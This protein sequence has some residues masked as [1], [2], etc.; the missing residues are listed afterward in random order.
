MPVFDANINDINLDF[1]KDKIYLNS[2][3]RIL[4]SDL[5]ASAVIR[6][7][8]TAPLIFDNINL[9]LE[10]ININK[11]AE[12]LRDY[13]VNSA[14][15]YT[16]TSS[17][18]PDFSGIIIKKAEITADKIKIKEL[19]ANNFIAHLTLND[20]MILE[21][22]D[23]KFNV[24]GGIS[25][26]KVKYNLLNHLVNISANVKNANAQTIAETLTDLKGQVYG[27]VA[28]EINVYCN[29]KSHDACVQTLGG[30]GNFEISD[31]KMPK[32]GSLEYL[33]KAGNLVKG[34]ITGLSIKGIIDLITPYKT[35]QFDSIKGNFKLKD[36]IANDLKIY[37][38]GKALNIF[39]NGSYNLNNQI[40]DMSIFGALTNN[41]SSVIGKIGAASLNTLFNTM[42]WINLSDI[43]KEQTDD[44]K[45]IPNTENA[46]RMF[47]AIIYGDINGNDYVRSF[48]WLK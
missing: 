31:G 12:I 37:S 43:P 35:G 23:F 28:G 2:K 13:D 27:N 1:R 20:K 29:G 21:V 19:L 22:P 9:N 32:L 42:P 7:K 47:N 8:L 18:L 4:T 48:K 5:K 41:F 25:S 15:T 10:T 6:N 14:R 3:G 30:N 24:A 26:G 44:I 33:L 45:Q 39:I 34:G 40:A 11:I 46:T 36:G 38:S 17:E 16:I